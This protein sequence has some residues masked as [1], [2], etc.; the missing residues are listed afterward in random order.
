MGLIYNS[1]FIFIK[2]KA[3]EYSVA[4]AHS[5]RA[6]AKKRCLKAVAKLL[7]QIVN[8]LFGFS[9]QRFS[10]RRQIFAGITTRNVDN[11]IFLFGFMH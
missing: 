9:I 1:I 8:V 10:V 11:D 6:L 3:T 5:L 2:K 4:F 7:L